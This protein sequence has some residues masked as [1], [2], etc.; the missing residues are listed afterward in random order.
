MNKSFKNLSN[1]FEDTRAKAISIESFLNNYTTLN[2][3]EEFNNK[4]QGEFLEM[5][6]MLQS[7]LIKDIE[8]LQN[9]FISEYKDAICTN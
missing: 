5:I 9:D 8:K 2:Q 7:D 3:F 1:A 6:R 4:M